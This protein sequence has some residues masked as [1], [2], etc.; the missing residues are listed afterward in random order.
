MAT[1]KQI[2]ANRQNAKCSIGPKTEDGKAV[3]AKNALKHGIFSKQIV[4]EE[5]SK[6]EFE[7]QR[8]IFTH[9]FTLRGY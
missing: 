9:N 6:K 7:A 1:Q 3:V 2:I 4:L 8:R 5:E